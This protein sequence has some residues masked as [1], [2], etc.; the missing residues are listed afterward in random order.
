MKP[1]V[2][3]LSKKIGTAVT[4]IRRDRQIRQCDLA[5]NLGIPASQLCKL[6]KGASAPSLNTFLRIAQ[7]LNVPVQDLFAACE[8]ATQEGRGARAHVA[9]NA[10]RADELP[11]VCTCEGIEEDIPAKKLGKLI[12]KMQEY[13]N[14]ETCCGVCR[15]AT[16]PLKLPFGITDAD[17]E[18]LAQR[19][20]NVCGIG[21]AIV[22]DYIEV[23]E[24]HG[25]H[26]F[27]EDLPKD[28]PSISFYD[29]SDDNGFIFVARN[30]NPEKQVFRLFHELG[31]IY[32]FTRR[33]GRPVS[34]TYRHKHFANVFAASFLMPR[35]MVLVTTA[36]F[37]LAPTQWSFDLI[38]RLKL[39]FSVSAEAFTIRLMEL[40]VL[41]RNLGHDILARI[42]KFYRDN[43]F[44]EPGGSRIALTPD[45]RMEDLAMIA[46]LKGGCR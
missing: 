21:S 2:N 24:N 32:L 10:G 35:F 3:D 34:L 29:E 41:D 19:V 36:S 45:A 23:L 11:A 1:R 38:V 15:A 37:N 18:A 13:K 44:K 46:E 22:L 6:E 8:L 5:K 9:V 39:R 12:L 20:R 25:L 17:A 31:M 40:D 26:I 42:R 4:R 7:E 30:V 33:G 14:L 43:H 16:I 28:V 27:V